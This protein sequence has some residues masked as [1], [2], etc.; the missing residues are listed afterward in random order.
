MNLVLKVDALNLTVLEF[1]RQAIN[2]S[3]VR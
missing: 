2:N 1:I 3:K